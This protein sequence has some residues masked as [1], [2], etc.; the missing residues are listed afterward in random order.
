M[1]YTV[2]EGSFCRLNGNGDIY[3]FFIKWTTVT[4][5]ELKASALVPCSRR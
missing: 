3:I 1:L 2:N 5:A 4:W